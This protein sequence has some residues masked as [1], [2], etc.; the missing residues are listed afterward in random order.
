MDRHAGFATALVIREQVFQELVSLLYSA[1]Q[2]GAALS[3]PLP[4]LNFALFQDVPKVSFLG[5]DPDQITLA[6]TAWGPAQITPPGGAAENR[7]VI[8]TSTITVPLQVALQNTK[9]QF[10]LDAPHA[11]LKGYDMAPYAGN[12]FSDTAK[13]YLCSSAIHDLIEQGVRT[14]LGQISKLIPPFDLAMLDKSLNAQNATVQFRVLQGILA[15]G[16]DITTDSVTTTGDPNLL[17]D[18][19]ELQDIA[20]ITN[21]AVVPVSY[22]FIEKQFKDAIESQQATFGPFSLVIEEG[23]FRIHGSASKLGGTVNFSLKAVPNLVRHWVEMVWSELD[24]SVNGG[25]HPE[26]RT[27]YELWFDPQ[28]LNVD[29]DA[30]WWVT[31]VQV[32]GGILTFGV[33]AL[34]IDAILN[35]IRAGAFGSILSGIGAESRATTQRF[36]LAGISHPN[37]YL[38]IDRYECHS[39]GVFLGLTY[40]PEFSDNSPIEGP[41]SVAA[42]ELVASPIVYRVT[43]ADGVLVTDPELRVRWTVRRLDQNEVVFTT[44]QVA[45]TFAE[46]STDVRSPLVQSLTLADVP[47]LETDKFSIECRVH[48]TLGTNVADFFNAKTQLEIRDKLDRSHPFV[49]WTHEAWTPIVNVEADGSHTQV[50]FQMNTRKSKIHRTA[51]PGRCRMASRN[52]LKRE[53]LNSPLEKPTPDYLDALPF[54]KADILAHRNQLCDYCFFGGPTKTIPLI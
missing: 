7:R 3:S 49:H 24:E 15:L 45:M 25:P 30:D 32:I 41:A 44:E 20:V 8:F 31:F 51:L 1:G 39:E 36:T 23:G 28:E 16:I 4:S 6:L 47:F 26:Q 14:K 37:M 46:D 10:T 29:V 9:L 22:G 2:I 50:G 33:A 11:E 21:S 48:R 42:E 35:G 54:A 43:L 19:S 52:S 12:E 17:S 40:H 34:T 5:S 53:G 27:S 38:H 13:A 18:F